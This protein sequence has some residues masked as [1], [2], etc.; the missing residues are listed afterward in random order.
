VI[1]DLPSAMPKINRLHTIINEYVAMMGFNLVQLRLVNNYGFVYESETLKDLG[2]SL[3]AGSENPLYSLNPELEKLVQSAHEAGVEMMPEVSVST[4][5]GGWYRSGFLANCPDHYCTGEGTPIDINN[6]GF[7]PVLFSVVGELRQVFTSRFV[8]LGTDEREASAECFAEAKITPKFDV[9]EK[10]IETLMALANLAPEE[11]I[12]TENR[13]GVRYADRAGVVT[14][15]RADQ[16]LEDVRAQGVDGEVAFVTID[17]FQGDGYDIFE[18]TKKAVAMKPLG[19]LAELRK[20]NESKWKSWKILKR[21]LAFAMGLSEIGTFW[22]IYNADTFAKHF[23]G[24]C[25]ALELD[26]TDCSPP[27]TF[28]QPVTVITESQEFVDKSCE[29]RT[30]VTKQRVAKKA[31]PYFKSKKVAAE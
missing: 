26:D 13:E 11:I 31:D 15:F 9:F 19:I 16:P 3:I 20:L 12:R 29:V 28:D 18:N 24:I 22:S 4:D 17:L 23:T 14:Q 30:S 2:H 7:P 27:G 5:A 1:L 10:K 25:E 6:E 21:L 8:H